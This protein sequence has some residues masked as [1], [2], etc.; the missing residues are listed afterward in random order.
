MRS[1]RLR[2]GWDGHLLL[3][4]ATAAERVLGLAAWTQDG[5]E[6]RERLV[7]AELPAPTRVVPLLARC[8]VAAPEAV[9]SGA[10][11]AVH[12][13]QVPGLAEPARLGEHL[14]RALDAGYRGLRLC[15]E[16][17]PAAPELCA[18]VAGS[19][20]QV[21]GPGR[22]SLLCRHDR[23]ARDGRLPALVAAHPHGLRTANLTTRP[24]GDGLAL[25]GEVDISNVDL[26][27]A[28]L[29]HVTHSPRP[30][31]WLDLTD[32]RFMDVA[33]CRELAS[34]TRGFRN[35]GGTVLLVDPLP[36]VAHVLRVLG[37]D[38]LRGMEI[39]GR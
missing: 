15:V 10:L 24:V 20:E 33:G 22:V 39:L 21:G 6:Q 34:S 16:I 28:A 38:Q 19:A 5:L 17:P 8:G 37:V 31:L 36:P 26:L 29:E 18:D 30:T 2:L 3:P 32:L 1:G 12:A 9:A 14:E 13:D 11:E 27:G 25:A 4:Y 7:C 35:N 23:A